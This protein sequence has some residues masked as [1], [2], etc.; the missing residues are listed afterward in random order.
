MADRIDAY[1][2]ALFEIAR[3]EGGLGH[4]EDQLFA[5]SQAYQSND[6]LRTTLTDQRIPPA[7][8]Q[9]IVEDILG[10]RAD[11][12]VVALISFVVAAGRAKDLP[13]IVGRLVSMAAEARGRE[14]AE[15]RSAIPLDDTL[16]QKLADAL[17]KATGKNVE[18]RV[19]VDPTVMGGVVAQIGDTVIDGSV[20]HRIEQLKSTALLSRGH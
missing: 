14:V 4:V 6:E 19:I 11:P 8:R 15:I 2:E 13:E 7:R 20:R 18:V 17:G 10:D 16:R 3:A 9:S 1:A 5:F 12:T